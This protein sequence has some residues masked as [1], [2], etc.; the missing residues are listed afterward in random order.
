MERGPRFRAALAFALAL[1]AVPASADELSLT[2]SN[3]LVTLVADNV[4]VRQILAEW[5]RVGQTR[6]VNGERVPGAQVT[7]RLTDVP[8]RLALE[9]LLRNVS[10]YVAAP[11]ATDL[12]TGSIYDRILIMPTSSQAPAAAA[13]PAAR[14][15]GSTPVPPVPMPVPT[16][17]ES[18]EPEPAEDAQNTPFV[19]FSP[20]RPQEFENANPNQPAAGPRRGMVG[21]VAQPVYQAPGTVPAVPQPVV[22]APAGAARPGEFVQPPTPQVPGMPAG[23]VPGVPR[24]SPAPAATP[25]PPEE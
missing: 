13:L 17:V 25:P 1:G 12:A 4:T 24:P 23:V 19:P 18:D 7:L 22:I 2:I 14:G 21:G 5:A 15:A 8:E 11:R 16:P 20:P 3:G 6:I 9:T 10:G